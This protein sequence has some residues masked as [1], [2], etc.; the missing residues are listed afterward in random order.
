MLG[1]RSMRTLWVKLVDRDDGTVDSWA[2]SVMTHR[3]G[4]FVGDDSHTRWQELP[5][6][7]TVIC[8]G[9]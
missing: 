9:P 8:C 1:S 5:L 2:V 4:A 7:W 6:S 3:V